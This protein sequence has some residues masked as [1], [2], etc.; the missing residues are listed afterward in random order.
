MEVLDWQ[1]LVKAQDELIRLRLH[2]PEMLVGAS[3]EVVMSLHL[4]NV[5]FLGGCLAFGFIFNELGGTVPLLR[6]RMLDLVDIAG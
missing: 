5:F 3:Q 6:R 4:I 2:L 1:L